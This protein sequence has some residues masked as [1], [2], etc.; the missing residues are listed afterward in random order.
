MTDVS[1]DL[2]P[3]ES[4]SPL[5]DIDSITNRE[6]YRSPL[7]FSEGKGGRRFGSILAPY[8]LTGQMIKC[9][10]S[11]CGRPH[12]HGYLIT[13][14]DGLETNIGKDCGKRHFK[15][16]FSSEVKRHD[17]LYDRRLKLEKIFALKI[18]ASEILQDLI[19]LK[20]EYG[21]LKSL[22]FRLRGALSRPENQK[23]DHK[24]KTG[25]DRLYRLEPPSKEEIDAYRVANN[26]KHAIPPAREVVIGRIEGFKFLKATHRDEEVFNYIEPLRNLSKTSREEILGWKKGEIDRTHSWF[27]QARQVEKIRELILEGWLFF[28]ADNIRSIESI[29][30]SSSSLDECL[31]DIKPIIRQSGRKFD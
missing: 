29:G 15:A 23:L 8:H 22:R 17:Q 10:I 3:G 6:Q 18:E 27:S 2:F 1:S 13:T 24:L 12:W 7:Q 11:T 5:L 31:R 21:I 28:T 9:G 20:G 19:E 4:I 26:K 30:I 25:D 16:D 14:S